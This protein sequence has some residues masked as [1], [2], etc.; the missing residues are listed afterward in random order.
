MD[1]NN[2]IEN[3]NSELLSRTIQLPSGIYITTKEFLEHSVIPFLP[4]SNRV[5]LI[6]DVEISMKQFIEECVLSQC[7]NDYNGD[8]KKY[9]NEIVKGPILGMNK[10]QEE[11]D[12][13]EIIEEQIEELK[14]DDIPTKKDEKKGEASVL[15]KTEN[16]ISLES[17][18]VSSLNIKDNFKLG[19][20]LHSMQ[21]TIAL[22][23]VQILGSNLKDE[24]KIQSGIDS[25]KADFKEAMNSVK[26]EEDMNIIR[27]ELKRLE[28]I[29]KIGKYFS[30][31]L[32]K[33]INNL[34]VIEEKLG[35]V[36]SIKKYANG[37]IEYD[38]KY[39]IGTKYDNNK[40]LLSAINELEYSLGLLDIA[41]K[42]DKTERKDVVESRNKKLL[43]DFDK[44][45]INIKNDQDRDFV[46]QEL[47]KISKI[48]AVGLLYYD[49]FQK[50]MNNDKTY[51]LAEVKQ[52]K[53]YKEDLKIEI[54]ESD[55]FYLDL[56]E[57]IRN[58][59]FDIDDVYK[60]R[61]KYEKILE[62]LE[63]YTNKGYIDFNEAKSITEKIEEKLEKLNKTIKTV[64]GISDLKF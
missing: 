42:Y 38:T 25:I 48:G 53:D 49:I 19:L 20:E 63:E 59:K 61:S 52:D 14:L 28:T 51:K 58:L 30:G 9:Y 21:Y 1:K 60:M 45:I 24:T 46:N 56:E 13:I 31:I 10:K 6:N 57:D 33:E 7:V 54:E 62:T 12:E 37:K 40:Q 43:E 50:R 64:D 15:K 47:E 26:T 35:E 29:G 18:Y 44:V 16:G 23:D 3:I 2:I 55:R 41:I 4:D 17:K 8:F 34:K 27:N 11:V 5:K 22:L 39:S 36:S 32:E